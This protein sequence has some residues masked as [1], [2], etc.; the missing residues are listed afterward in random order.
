[1]VRAWAS[2]TCRR[3]DRFLKTSTRGV[4]LPACPPV[5]RPHPLRHTEAATGRRRLDQD[6]ARHSRPRPG[7][8]RAGQ[9]PA[10]TA[11]ARTPAVATQDQ[12]TTRRRRAR[13]APPRRTAGRRSGQRLTSAAQHRIQQTGEAGIEVIATQRADALGSHH[14]LVDQSRLAQHLEVVRAGRLDDRQIEAVARALAPVGRQLANDPKAHRVAERVEDGR[15]VEIG[16]RRMIKRRGLLG[17][18][19]PPLS[20]SC[21]LL[22]ASCPL[23]SASCP[24]L[25]VSRSRILFAGSELLADRRRLATRFGL[26]LT[27]P[28]LPLPAPPS[29]PRLPVRPSSPWPLDPSC[30]A[31]PACPSSA[32]STGPPAPFA[33]PRRRSVDLR[34]RVVVSPVDAAITPPIVRQ[35]SNY[36]LTCSMIIVLDPEEAHAGGEQDAAGGGQPAGAGK[37]AGQRPL[38]PHS[39]CCRRPR[40]QPR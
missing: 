31:C 22:T 10:G 34:R 29:P 28:R 15:Q 4:S 7:S 27:A 3:A 2:P 20:A 8:R 5:F 32:P 26:P 17:G 16:S 9:R 37:R 23:L 39:P 25:C 36:L 1:M 35:P 11:Q 24:L 19:S 18:R 30:P 14:A 6:P 33:P 21:P 12:T 13:Q 40:H 38:G